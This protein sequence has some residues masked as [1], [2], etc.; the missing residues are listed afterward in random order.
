MH[1]ALKDLKLYQQNA[2]KWSIEAIIWI[3]HTEEEGS[4]HLGV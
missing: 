2:M 4:L 1:V 3:I